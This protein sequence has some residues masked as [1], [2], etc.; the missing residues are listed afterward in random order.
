MRIGVVLVSV[1]QA[2]VGEAPAL[3]PKYP[4]GCPRKARPAL[5]QYLTKLAQ[6]EVGKGPHT[7]VVSMMRGGESKGPRSVSSGTLKARINAGSLS[8][9]YRGKQHI[10]KP[11][12]TAARSK[13]MLLAR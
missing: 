12:R 9:K 10:P 13:S 8:H 2:D 4:Q 7:R 3:F 5:P 11:S 1:A 6:H